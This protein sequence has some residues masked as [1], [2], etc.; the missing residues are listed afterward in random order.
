[1]SAGEIDGAGVLDQTVVL[2][3]G[4]DP[5]PEVAIF[6]LN[7]QRAVMLADVDRPGI[8]DFLEAE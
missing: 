5:K 8:A 3:V 7:G 6:H 2:F 4:T 1:V